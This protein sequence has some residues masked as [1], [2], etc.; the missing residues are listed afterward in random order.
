MS[1]VTAR[2]HAR[3][4]WYLQTNAVVVGWLA[5]LGV[6][7]LTHQMVPGADWLMVHL[8]LLGA[9]STAILIWSQHFAD[10]LV[11]R[12]A[13]SGRRSL[14][15]RLAGHTLGAILVMVGMTLNAFPL[16]LGGGLVVG[17]VAVLHA[18]LLGGQL[19]R[20]KP[21]RFGSLV[22]YYVAASVSLAIGV[23]LG[24]WMAG[25]ATG[26]D[27]HARLYVAHII[28]N[29][30]GW[31]GLTAVGTL[32]LL[33]PT[34]LR[35]RL[36]DGTDAAARTALPLLAAGVLVAAGAS[37]AGQPIGVAAGA[38]LYLLGL[39]PVVREAVRQARQAPP[40]T[41]A[42][43]SLAASMAWLAFSVGALG[44]LV[45]TAPAPIEA[46]DRLGWLL[47]PLLAGFAVQLLLGALSYL[48]PMVSGGG[49]QAGKAAAAELDRAPLFRLLVVNGGIV[50]YLLPVPSLVKVVL[51]L[52]VFGVLLSFL[53]LLVRAVVV[54]GRIRSRGAAPAVPLLAD[55]LAAVT[56]A[57]PGPR[58]TRS[59]MAAAAVAVLVLAV[60]V[61]VALDPVT[62]GVGS[63]SVTARNAATIASGEVTTA[64]VTMLDMRFSPSRL[65]VPAGDRLELTVTNDDTAVHDLT[66]ANGVT[67]GRVAPGETVTVDAGVMAASSEGWCSIAGHRQMGMVL[68]IAV[69]GSTAESTAE[70][71]EAAADHA[72]SG[73]TDS[74][75]T[76]VAA[77]AA[78]DLGAQA[79]PSPGFEARDAAL[80][81][82]SSETHHDYT[83]RVGDTE[84]EVAPGVTQTLWPFNGT[85]PGPTLRGTVG[86]T[87]T[88]TLIND[89]TTGHS[90][91]FHAGALAPDGPMRTI[92]PGETLEYSFTA[93]RSGIWLY[94]CSTTPMSLHIANGMFGAVVIDPAGL[95]PV[96]RE[97]LLVQSEFYLGPQGGIADSAKIAAATPDLVVFNGYANQY[98]QQPLTAKVGE[99]IRFWVLDA[100]PNL[101]SSFHIVGGQFDTVYAEGEY[102][103]R[104]GGSTGTG[105]SQT[106]ALAPAQGG[107]VEL[108][109]PEAGTYSFVTHAMT[110]AERGAVGHVLVVP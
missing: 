72:D 95:D 38:L 48:V 14:I 42:G 69:T 21:T 53:V 93:T 70:S 66:L 35:T 90:L 55:R 71:T 60:T 44:V 80:P 40:T 4:T 52:L 94:H 12:P 26:A 89:A 84:V 17:A 50:F 8:L 96:D 86:D 106:L 78:D 9:V 37:L 20:A 100:G 33:W 85:A 74:G 87:F 24:I 68:Q 46:V 45:A 49:P 101:A 58:R 62:A 16:V 64:T 83:F 36:G 41:F 82:A 102:L 56:A 18:I 61:G 98:A 6:A 92:E 110:D 109:F 27:L 34:V 1:P 7:V 76:D 32:L 47:V 107:F 10:T 54:G 73:A 5:V 23:G 25:P 11:R 22:R 13:L 59:G 67:S 39:M 75:A 79:E 77:T 103:L 43:W 104:Q 15:I 57:A 63:G 30:L 31:V 99:R 28:L 2:V 97:Y 81:P 29:V 88:I 105:G 108:S 65:T 51:S 19:R 91:D 3:R